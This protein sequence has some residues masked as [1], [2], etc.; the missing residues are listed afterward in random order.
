MTATL[1]QPDADRF[2]IFIDAVIESPRF[3]FSAFCKAAKLTADQALAWVARPDIA[4]ALESCITFISAAARIRHSILETNAMGALGEL[5][6]TSTNDIELRRAAT[7]IISRHKADL[8][9]SRA[10]LPRATDPS[11]DQRDIHR[12]AVEV[13]SRGSPRSGIPGT[14]SQTNPHPSGVQVLPTNKSPSHSTTSSPVD[15]LLQL[16][17]LADTLRLNKEPA[18]REP[19]SPASLLNRVGAP[20]SLSR[21]RP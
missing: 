8:R 10:T 19:H 7:T 4:A 17:L 21:D 5:L 13:H 16:K 1:S 12:E 9:A 3:N 20:T 18:L 14:A 6:R 11:S 15:S 2:S